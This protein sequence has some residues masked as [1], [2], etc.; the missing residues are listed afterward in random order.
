MLLICPVATIKI[1]SRI[2]CQ[3]QMASVSLRF[4]TIKV[5]PDLFK[6]LLFQCD[7]KLCRVVEWLKSK[8]KRSVK[9]RRKI[10]LGRL[11][12]AKLTQNR[13]RHQTNANL[14]RFCYKILIGITHYFY[15]IA[16]PLTIIC[17][18]LYF[19]FKPSLGCAN[20]SAVPVV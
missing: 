10:R 18:Y 7:F 8:V 20:S 5:F 15:S 1:F 6:D 11:R 14:E 12:T 2:F 13:T 16:I 3:L 4:V 9:C 19:I 17:Y